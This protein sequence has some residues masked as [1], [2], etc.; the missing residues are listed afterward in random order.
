VYDRVNIIY[1]IVTTALED[2]DFRSS[3][4]IAFIMNWYIVM[5]KESVMNKHKYSGCV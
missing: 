2:L 3:T 5:L 1:N 4:I